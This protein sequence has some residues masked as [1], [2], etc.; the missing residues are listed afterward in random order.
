MPVSYSRQVA[1]DGLALESQLGV[2][3]LGDGVVIHTSPQTPD[4]LP[5]VLGYADRKH[6]GYRNGRRHV[7]PGTTAL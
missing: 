1:L 7:E 5:V 2:T 4:Q 6:Q 3:R